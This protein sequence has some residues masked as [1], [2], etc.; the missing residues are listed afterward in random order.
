MSRPRRLMIALTALLLIAPACGNAKGK[1]GTG[2]GG[3]VK[4]PTDGGEKNRKVHKTISG[5]PGVTDSEIAYAIIGTKK[6]NPLGTCL[7][8]CYSD[9]INAYF[10]YRNSQG[11]IYGRKLVVGQSIDDQL[12]NNQ[13]AALSVTSGNKAFGAFV[14]GLLQQGWGDLNDA[15]VPTYTWGIDGTSA[16]NREAIFPSTV[17]GCPDCTRRVVPYVAMKAG[18][19]HAGVLGYSTSQNSQVCAQSTAASF[20]MYAKDTGVD[21]G[22]VKDDLP[23]GLA[24]G[25]GPEITAMKKAKVDFIATCFDLNAM[26]TLAQELDRQ[27][28]S[29]VTLYHPNTYNPAFVK[30]AGSLFEGDYVDVQF[31]PFE[32]ASIPALAA[33]QTWI[34]KTNKKPTELAMVGWINATLA[35]QGLL[36]AGPEFDRA[37]LLAATNS[38]KRFTAD[39]MVSAVDWTKAHTPYTQ[40][41]RTKV[42]DLECGTVVKVVKGTFQS[43]GPREKPWLCWNGEDL[44]WSEPVPTTFS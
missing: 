29:N 7:L 42:P 5:V 28:M 6:N 30:A 38:M 10:A 31:R 24:N 35:Y 19:K 3:T 40:A 26:K 15:G 8:D 20:K 17:I 27:G 4:A 18:A 44:K 34:K 32:A 16:A 41:T 14:A 36:A 37:K 22:F 43:F 39:G 21:L 2:S 11:G 9:G 25:L 33:F 1:A 12:G 23:Y 13:A